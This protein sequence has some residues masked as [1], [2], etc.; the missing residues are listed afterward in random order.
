MGH[1]TGIQRAVELFDGSPT[2]LAA[3]VGN[4]VIR[5]HVEHWLKTGRVSSEKCAHVSLAT[6]ISVELLN[7]Q[8]D[9]A[10]IRRALAAG[11]D[12]PASEQK[13]ASVEE[14]V[15]QPGAL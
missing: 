6:G 3:A 8:E 4:G 5:Q 9:W 1:K 7:P 15:T 12:T 2:K 11:T 10:A 14:P 13:T